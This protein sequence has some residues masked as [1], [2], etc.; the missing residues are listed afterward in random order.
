M[1]AR[2][3]LLLLLGASLTVACG[4]PETIE[5]E[6]DPMTIAPW[7]MWGGSAEF[8]ATTLT[9]GLEYTSSGQLVRVE[10]KRPESFR[11]LF[12]VFV[13]SWRLSSPAILE[14]D[15]N[16]Q[17]GVGRSNLNLSPFETFVFRF[18]PGTG[19]GLLK[20]SGS[21]NGPVRDD[22]APTPAD[23]PTPNVID[24]IVGQDIQ[25]GYS[26]FTGLTLPG[27]TIQAQIGVS[28][29]PWHHA[30]PDWV[31]RDFAGEEIKGR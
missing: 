14:I 11:F 29:A 18:G 21:V 20:Y 26:G 31:L 27:D 23:P 24:T 28:L 4:P 17:A 10:Y 22:T 8:N 19:G 9:P 5:R 3:A 25:V 30:R 15:F 7:H 16:V 6:D 1:I 13:T 12:Y 2:R